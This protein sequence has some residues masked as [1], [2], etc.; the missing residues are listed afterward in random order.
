MTEISKDG[1]I[2]TGVVSSFHSPSGMQAWLN[3]QSLTFCERPTNGV[4]LGSV[5]TNRRML[6]AEFQA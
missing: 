3:H 1:E 6:K 2:S 4:L 5:H